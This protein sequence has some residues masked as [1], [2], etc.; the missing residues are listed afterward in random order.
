MQITAPTTYNGITYWIR[1]T[2]PK[3]VADTG[4]YQYVIEHPNTGETIKSN[5][6]Y[7]R[8]IACNQA[9]RQAIDLMV[10]VTQKRKPQVLEPMSE[11]EPEAAPK[12]RR[13]RAS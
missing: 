7:D 5:D 12:R 3:T 9:A 13:R 11:P 2:L 10:G 4:S 6:T 1:G 8:V